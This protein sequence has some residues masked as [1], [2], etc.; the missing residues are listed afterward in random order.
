MGGRRAVI[1]QGSAEPYGWETLELGDAWWRLRWAQ[2]PATYELAERYGV[3]DEDVRERLRAAGVELRGRPP[4]G[5]RLLF[6][7]P[8]AP[9]AVYTVR[10]RAAEW[11][12]V[13]ESEV[14]C[15]AT[16]W[17]RALQCVW[18]TLGRGDVRLQV[19]GRRRP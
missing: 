19:L 9:Q 3:P 6:D 13:R 17:R 5:Q 16:S 18:R 12:G 4:E 11:A 2:T 1:P 8:A 14:E 7:V 15:I 10:I